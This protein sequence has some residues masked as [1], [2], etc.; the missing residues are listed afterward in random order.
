LANAGWLVSPAFDLVFLCN[1][2][3]LFALLPGYLAADGTPHIE[4][5]QL[6]FITTPHR[7]LTLVLVGL[8]PDRR[9]GRSWLFGSLA[10]AS[11]ALVAGVYFCADGFLCLM[12]IDYIWNGWHFAAQHAG[13]LRIYARK[14]PGGRPWLE[15]HGLRFFIC[16][17]IARTA[18]WTTGWLEEWPGILRGVD[19]VDWGVLTVGAMLIGLELRDR[20][21]R[22]AKLSYLASVCG[23]YGSL[24]V[25]LHF[26]H[27]PLILGLTTAAALFHATE[28]IALVTHYAWRRQETGSTG[29]FRALARHWGLF[30]VGYVVLLG[31]L[32]AL[33]Q[34]LDRLPA[35]WVGLNLWAAFLHYAYDGLIWK[36]RRPATA[37]ALGAEPVAS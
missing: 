26:R 11:A 17:I 16:Y 10:L 20:P 34:S 35:W 28:Y 19:L 9:E 18:G 1:L 5:W 29:A 27:R 31:M 25:A 36:L 32:G 23:L 4:F 3:W 7:W 30:L 33:V 24:L 37:R 15:R 13:V 21:W 6:Y 22:V 14:S 2:G 8:D 12:L